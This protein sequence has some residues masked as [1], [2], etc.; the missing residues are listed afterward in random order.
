MI[1]LA[2]FGKG[3]NHWESSTHLGLNIFDILQVMATYW[4]EI[5]KKED[6]FRQGQSLF[7]G[8]NSQILVNDVAKGHRLTPW[9]R[10]LD[11]AISIPS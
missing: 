5:L 1:W 6:F 7:Q 9:L 8:H 11:V 4:N 10:S 3:I 2:N